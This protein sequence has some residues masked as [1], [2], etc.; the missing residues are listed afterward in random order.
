MMWK[1]D[2]EDVAL[3][4]FS[5]CAFISPVQ[6]VS[7]YPVA[8]FPVFTCNCNF[9]NLFIYLFF[10]VWIYSDEDYEPPLS[11]DLP[12][13]SRTTRQSSS[14][15]PRSSSQPPQSS[16]QVGPS[17]P[18]PPTLHKKR[19]R[20]GAPTESEEE[21]RWRNRDELDIKPDP[22]R[23]RP[24]RT[25][26]PTFDTTRAWSPIDLFQLFFSMS[27]VNTLVQKTNANAAKR[28]QAEMS[29]KWAVLTAKDFYMF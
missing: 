23:F 16:P 8:E 5:V 10:C 2:T 3:N 12:S 28:K 1:Y 11:S 24:S 21:D 13:T 25:P 29:F 4:T 17:A 6:C 9:V 18:P 22:L 26:G 27:V 15:P 7:I 19:K 20:K 14:Q